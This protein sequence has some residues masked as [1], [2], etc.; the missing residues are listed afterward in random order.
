MVC[1]DNRKIGG[2]EKVR[3]FLSARVATVRNV[4]PIPASARCR[5]EDG[6]GAIDV[7]AAR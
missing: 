6:G 4:D 7:V 5:M 1:R 2:A 3:H